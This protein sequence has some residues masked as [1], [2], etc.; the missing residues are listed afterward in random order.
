MSRRSPKAWRVTFEYLWQAVQGGL[1]EAGLRE[2]GCKCCDTSRYRLILTIHQD[3]T[4]PSRDI[5]NH[6]KRIMD[7]ITATRLVWRDD[8]Q[9][10]ELIV[11]RVPCER[12]Q[13]T[14]VVLSLERLG[15]M[16]DRGGKVQLKLTP[17]QQDEIRK[18]T[19]KLT[20]TLELS[21]MELEERIAPTL[22]WK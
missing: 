3:Y 14:K 22:K 19:G 7:C 1:I 20:D 21:I 12:G 9:V 5:D 18:A 15:T 2:H 4:L 16:Q 11:R 10:D 13:G 8:E 6:A 17:E